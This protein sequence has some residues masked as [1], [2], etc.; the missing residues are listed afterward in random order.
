[1]IDF[2]KH[3]LVRNLITLSLVAGMCSWSYFKN[4]GSFWIWFFIPIVFLS[5]LIPFFEKRAVD[6]ESSMMMDGFQLKDE[7]EENSNKR[8]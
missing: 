3:H 1:M 2:L 7:S 8:F 4:N 6:K 5:F